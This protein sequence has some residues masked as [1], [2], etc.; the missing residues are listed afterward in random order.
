MPHLGSS[1]ARPFVAGSGKAVLLPGVQIFMRLLISRKI[2]M[3]TR[4]LSPRWGLGSGAWTWEPSLRQLEEWEFFCVPELALCACL[5]GVP[6]PRKPDTSEM[7]QV[8]ANECG[9]DYLWDVCVVTQ[10]YVTEFEPVPF[11]RHISIAPCTCITSS[12]PLSSP[13][14]IGR[15]PQRLGAHLTGPQ[16]AV[17]A[18]RPLLQDTELETWSPLL[19]VPWFLSNLYY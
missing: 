19:W 16:S 10:G 9:D 8:T 6:R 14:Q 2:R 3:E 12:N 17:G 5:C 1:E 13:R 7:T 4:L 11:V 15:T 18:E